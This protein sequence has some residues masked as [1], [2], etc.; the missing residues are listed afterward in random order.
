L[1]AELGPRELADWRRDPSRPSPLVLDV[2]EPWE[3][4]VCRIE[5]SLHVPLRS[6]PAAAD[7]LPRDRDI[8]VVCH[9]GRRS[10]HA[11]V[12]LARSG[13]PRVINLRGGVAAWADEVDPAMP[14]Y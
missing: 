6:L 3:Y 7:E 10:L 4:E 8:V 5:D 11:A 13:F 9:H 2:R 12:W 14:R 1:I